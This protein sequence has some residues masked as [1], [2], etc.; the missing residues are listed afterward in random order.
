MFHKLQAMWDN[1]MAK[2]KA[3]VLQQDQVTDGPM[4]ETD[5]APPTTTKVK[6][7]KSEPLPVPVKFKS[8]TKITWIKYPSN[9]SQIYSRGLEMCFISKDLEQSTAFVLC[10]DF[11]HDA[12]MAQLNQKNI[13][14][15]G[16]KYDCGKNKPIDTENVRICVVNSNNKDFRTRI[17]ACVNFLNQIESEMELKPTKIF[18]VENP[19]AKY[20]NGAFMFEGSGRWLIAPPMLSLFTLLIR[21]GFKHKIGWSWRRTVQDAIKNMD[22]SA[23]TSGSS[24]GDYLSNALNGIDKILTHGYANIFDKEI[25]KNYPNLDA[26]QLHDAFGI[27]GF[28]QERCKSIAPNWYKDIKKKK[29]NVLK[30]LAKEIK[31]AEEVK[32]QL[33]P[34]VEPA[35]EPKLEV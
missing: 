29:P 9:L 6:K 30:G 26:S 25:K 32:P 15:Y 2:K 28:T 7:A 24:D 4:L 8:T 20:A 18:E 35:V 21:V 14:I 13:S 10:K 16:F 23:G 11:L 31:I 19:P 22:N 17:K 34:V 3:A 12:L 1:I 33:E 27:V 5:V